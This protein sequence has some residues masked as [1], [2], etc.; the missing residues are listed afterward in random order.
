MCGLSGV[1]P[2]GSIPLVAL[3]TPAGTGCARPSNP[4]RPSICYPSIPKQKH[5]HQKFARSL[6]SQRSFERP[7]EGPCKSRPAFCNRNTA[8][9]TQKHRPPWLN[10]GRQESEK[11]PVIPKQRTVIP[12]P[13]PGSVK[14]KSMTF[15][16]KNSIV[17]PCHHTHPAKQ[18]MPNQKNQ[19]NPK[20]RK[21]LLTL[22]GIGYI[23]I[24]T[25][26]KGAAI[27]KMFDNQGK[28]RR[29]I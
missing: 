29:R 28:E 15:I 7:V 16:P 18:F 10:T 22:F 13:D 2:S 26:T 20:K 12:G 14:A 6:H 1:P 11:N 19:K 8:I 4:C 21:I 25:A 5:R 17:T 3:R 9:T 27:K 23:F 24:L